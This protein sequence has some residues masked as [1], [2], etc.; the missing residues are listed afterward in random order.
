LR[1]T[2]E[3]AYDSKPRENLKVAILVEGG[4]EQSEMTE[5]RKALD[6]AGAMTRDCF[7][8]QR[9]RAGAERQGLGDEFGGRYR[10]R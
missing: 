8:S 9:P 4:L 5:P 7:A 6:K 3:L 2:A 10:T 1:P